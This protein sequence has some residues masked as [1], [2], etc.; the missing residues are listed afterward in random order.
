M[1]LAGRGAA[2]LAGAM[3]FPDDGS[4]IGMD[5][6]PHPGDIDRKES[7]AVLSRQHTAGFERLPAPA[8]KAEDPV[9]LR[10]GVP[11]L[12]IGQFAAMGLAGADKATMG[13]APQRLHLFCREAHHLVLT[14]KTGSGLARVTP[15]ISA[16]CLRSANS[17]WRLRRGSRGSQ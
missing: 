15:V 17:P 6:Q 2:A 12:Q 1:H 10:D 7:A 8:V 13:S 4:A 16:P 14:L 9:G 3:T 11:A 5:G